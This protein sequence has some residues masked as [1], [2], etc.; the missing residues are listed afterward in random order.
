MPSSKNND[1]Q[2]K[3]NN[4]NNK[5]KR[6]NKSGKGNN[7]NNSI[8]EKGNIRNL[9]D[10]EYDYTSQSDETYISHD[11]DRNTEIIKTQYN[12]IRPKRKSAIV[13]T[14]KIKKIIQNSSP[15]TDN[16]HNSSQNTSYTNTN[17]YKSKV[18]SKNN[19]KPLLVIPKLSPK[20]STSS[21]FDI[22]KKHKCRDENTMKRSRDNMEN[23]SNT[24]DV[25]IEDNNN[26]TPNTANVEETPRK[27]ARTDNY[28]AD[29][30]NI[31]IKSNKNTNTNTNK[32]LKG[33]DDLDTSEE[34]YDWDND[35]SDDEDED[36]N[37][38]DED[39]DEDEL[40]EEEEDDEE[41]ELDD[42]ELDE[43][44]DE[45]DED[46]DEDEEEDEDEKPVKKNKSTKKPLNTGFNGGILLSL[47]GAPGGNSMVPKRYNIKKESKEVKKFYDLITNPPEENTIDNQIDQFKALTIEKQ[48]EL[49]EALE[50]RPTTNE[51]GVN[52]ML[53]ILTMKLPSEIKGMI[54]SKYN[55]LQTLEP[56]SSEY[57]KMRN[58]LDKV[59]SIPFGIYKDI[60]VRLEDGAAVCTDFM[61]NAKKCLDD[62]VYGQDESKL[63]IMQFIST[64][65]SN[66]NGRGLSLLLVGE[67][68][69]GKTSLIKNGIAK[70]LGWPF[71]F[72]SLGGD[73]DAST[74]TGHQLVYESSH[75]GKIVNSLIASKSMS[76]V[77]MFDEI[78]KISQTPKGEEVQNLL[79]HLTDPVQNGE[80]EDKYLAGIPIDLSKVMFVFSANDINKID[81]VLLD[82]LTVITVKGYDV[83]QKVTIGE[84]YLLPAALKEVNLTERV[85][86]SRDILEHIVQEY[87]NEEKG[88]RELKRCIEQVTQ[89][90]NMLRMY[91]SPDLPF[92]IKDFSLP[93]IVKK[94][95]IKLFLKKRENTNAPPMGMYI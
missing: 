95:H 56:S 36:Y 41:D 63:Q 37:E 62:A 59:V 18:L 73:S 28:D 84:Q 79:V 12:Y 19:T 40:D 11:G 4:N 34:E 30:E 1:K 26:S 43:D 68:G 89:K 92:Y 14:K 16:S 52:L 67:P 35:D 39:E 57:Y 2:N 38:E 51:T 64:K 58:W 88:V 74:Y 66:P 10:Y 60:P 50:N 65:I 31:N 85:A 55:S 3:K 48:N 20:S 25:I 87:A 23:N 5:Y 78:D 83:K 17:K 22:H 93:F 6:K 82:R 90:I 33:N 29:D 70:A 44:D 42:D 45:E 9:I 21:K 71:N 76:T 81:K 80:F 77:L 54:L 13:A 49:I 75:C 7:D 24:N 94:D 91:N 15:K 53:K 32:I 46:Y 72:I 47:T 8:D 27:K 61:R 86:I 69:V